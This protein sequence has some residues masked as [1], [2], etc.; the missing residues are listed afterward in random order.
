MELVLTGKFHMA[1]TDH[2]TAKKIRVK[3]RFSTR[4]EFQWTLLHVLFK[5]IIEMRDLSSPRIAIQVN[6]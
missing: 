3:L 2:W 6:E 4:P 1:E 5:E